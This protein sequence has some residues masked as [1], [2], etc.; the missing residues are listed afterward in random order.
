VVVERVDEC[1]AVRGVK[2]ERLAVEEQEHDVRQRARPQAA[3]DGEV[4]HIPES[5]AFPLVVVELG[6]YRPEPV[7][8][9][10]AATAGCAHEQLPPRARHV[11][12]ASIGADD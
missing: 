12:K 10:A 6:G 11:D 9:A 1:L 3:A 8:R 7:L 5:S 2:P 4:Y